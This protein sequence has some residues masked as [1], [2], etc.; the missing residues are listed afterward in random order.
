MSSIQRASRTIGLAATLL[1]L[2]GTNGLAQQPDA[3]GLMG[4]GRFV[5]G[6]QAAGL[7]ELNERL[8]ARTEPTF[9]EHF[10]T[11]GFAFDLWLGRWLLGVEGHWLLEQERPTLSVQRG[12][13]GDFGFL[14]V[15]YALQ[16]GNL[17]LY[18]IAGIGAGRMKLKSTEY[19]EPSFDEVLEDPGWSSELSQLYFLVHGALRADYLIELSRKADIVSGISI[20]VQ[21]GY[22]V[23]F[24]H[25]DWKLDG[26]TASDGPAIGVEGGYF[27][28]AVGLWTQRQRG[29]E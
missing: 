11:L 29:P 24:G 1:L 5:A 27:R 16:L 21:A 9:D 12:L 23:A 17:R 2:I 8:A 25:T 3:G 6:W 10:L 26:S 15:G 19:G 7:E 20:G 22:N 13:S 28:V 4:A 14:D 18:P